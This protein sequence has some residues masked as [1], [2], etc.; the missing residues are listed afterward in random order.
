MK[1]NYVW[2]DLITG[3]FS[4]SW[5]IDNIVTNSM[6]KDMIESS[7]K[8]PNSRN[9]KLIKYECLNDPEFKLY[10]KMRLR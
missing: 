2:L 1:A 6:M 3:N 9:W 5:Q 4:N 8:P 10:N 7:S